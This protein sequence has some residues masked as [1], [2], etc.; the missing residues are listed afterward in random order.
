MRYQ[1]VNTGHSLLFDL[2]GSL[3]RDG[4]R[5]RRRAVGPGGPVLVSDNAGRAGL[6]DAW[7]G[8]AITAV[9]KA[10]A[11]RAK[12]CKRPS[13]LDEQSEWI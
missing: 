1:H 10:R 4:R 13:S 9:G 12:C 11:A 7:I 6:V 5:G 2:K 8:A 3:C